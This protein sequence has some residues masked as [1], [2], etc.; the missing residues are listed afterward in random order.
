MTIM[1]GQLLVA[2]CFTGPKATTT[3]LYLRPQHTAVSQNTATFAKG[4]GS[5]QGFPGPRDN[6]L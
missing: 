3:T 2:A 4:R 6:T 1:R 5:P